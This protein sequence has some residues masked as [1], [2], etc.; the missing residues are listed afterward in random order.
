MKCPICEKGEMENIKD[1]IKQDGIVFEAFRCT[2]CREEILNM[3][4]LKNLAE[5]YRKLRKAKG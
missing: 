4:Q 5:N 1:S 2:S 3:K